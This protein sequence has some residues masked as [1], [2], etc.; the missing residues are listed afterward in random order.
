MPDAWESLYP[1]CLNPS[2]PD[3]N[4]DCDH[5][6]FTNLQEYIAHTD[7]TRADSALRAENFAVTG[8]G[9]TLKFTGVAG[10]QYGLDRQIDLGAGAWVRVA[11]SIPETDGE[12]T[13]SD[14]EPPQE[15]AY[16]RIVA[17][18]P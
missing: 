4:G 9:A 15:N 13:L 17:E 14:P 1:S 8:T 2:V 6:G 3:A 10:R 16:Y 5:D 18:F 7:P 12:V 11:T